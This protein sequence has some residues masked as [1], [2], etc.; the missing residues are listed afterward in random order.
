MPD[1]GGTDA[2]SW[3]ALLSLIVLALALGGAAY[4]GTIAAF[5]I[6]SANRDA[7]SVVGVCSYLV[8]AFAFTAG[9]VVWLSKHRRWSR[10]E[11]RRP[12]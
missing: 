6:E 8:A 2:V 3:W 9:H 12:A 5:T 1:E 11:P 4:L 7:G 10:S